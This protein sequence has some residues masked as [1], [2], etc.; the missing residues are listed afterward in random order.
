M[1]FEKVSKAY[2]TIAVV[3]FN[4]VILLVVLNLCALS[5]GIFDREAMAHPEDPIPDGN[6]LTVYEFGPLSSGFDVNRQVHYYLED[7][8]ILRMMLETWNL[9]LVCDGG[10]LWK[11]EPFN[12]RFVSVDEAGFRRGDVQGPWPVDDDA[13][14]VFVFGGSTTFGYGVTDNLTIP[15]ALQFYLRESLTTDQINV[16][17]FGRAAYFSVVEAELFEVLLDDGVVPDLAIFIDGLNDFVFFDGQPPAGRCIDEDSTLDRWNSTLICDPDGSV[18]A[19]AS[20]GDKSDGW[21]GRT[22]I[23]S[24]THRLRD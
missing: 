22:R 7:H 13:F 19:A 8:E 3:F 4:T 6:P 20:A 1:N 9:L 5:Y 18:L 14:N 23:S 11:E 15:A 17:N 12:G 21:A 16:Y 2:S 24:R 10:N